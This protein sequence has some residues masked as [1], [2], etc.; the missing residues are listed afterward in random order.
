M[1]GRLC[2]SWLPPIHP[3]SFLAPLVTVPLAGL[4]AGCGCLFMGRKKDG[5][6]EYLI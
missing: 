2:G 3:G 4:A 1:Q 5:S 6:L